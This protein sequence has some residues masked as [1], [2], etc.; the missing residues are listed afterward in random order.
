MIF[1]LATLGSIGDVMPFLAVA[2][3]LRARGHRVVLASNAGYAQLV[4]SA[5]FEMAVIWDRGARDLDDVLIR[6]P[7]AAWD[8]VRS[9][10]FEPATAPARAAIAHYA[11]QG[12]C[13]VLASWSVYGAALAHR[14]LGVPLTT[15]YLSPHA[16]GAAGNGPGQRIG[17]FPDWFW[18]AEPPP[19]MAMT[20]FPMPDD[21]QLPPLPP[22]LEAFLAMG[23]PPLLF[24]PGS[25]MR[26]AGD[27]FAAALKACER[28]G[29]RGVFLSPYQDQIPVLPPTVRH[30]RYV[31]LQRLAPRAAAIV[32][33]GGI[34]T[35]AQAM[36]AGLPQLLSPV[37]FDQFDNAA[38]LEKLGVGRRLGADMAD[39]L[40]AVLASAGM[41]ENCVRLRG[42]FGGNT[43]G[44]I[45]AL[46]EKRA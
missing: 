44:A 46:L 32:H 2:G 43:I 7:A 38:R 18:A 4:Q 34:G 1:V 25:F 45:C 14:D 40:A 11:S 27:F 33:H 24:I 23:P 41:R 10:M 29:L 35:A 9:E 26:Q 5:G 19:G 36:R 13:A 30:Y 31:S 20:D 21:A 15:A 37:F 17:F 16:V 8:R 42:R 12:P 22:D 6:D 39:D 3:G 28:L